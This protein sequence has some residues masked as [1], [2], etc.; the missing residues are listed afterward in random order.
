[1]ARRII[2]EKTLIENSNINKARQEILTAIRQ[3]LAKSAPFDAARRQHHALPEKPTTTAAPLVSSADLQKIS[4]LERFRENLV[5]IGGSCSIVGGERE[6]AAAIQAIF[7][8]SQARRVAV[9]DAA[10]VEKTIGFLQTDA[11][12]IKNASAAALFECDFGVT[13]AQWAIAETGTLVLESEKEF[14]RLASLVPPVHICLL[15]MNNMRRTLGEILQILNGENLSRAITFITGPSRTS[16]I[17]LTLAIG[18]H[19]PAELHVI[20]IDR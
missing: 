18:V 11:E 4:L 9:S 14:N 10:L 16:D 5:S 6:G 1:M 13:S 17:E 19:G 20:V 15:E 3:N 7:D 8:R 12:F 2:E